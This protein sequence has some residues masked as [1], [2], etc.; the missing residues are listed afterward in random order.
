LPHI[1]YI[2]AKFKEKLVDTT[3]RVAEKNGK[4]DIITIGGASR[5]LHEILDRLAIRLSN[6]V[7]AE[8]L[9]SMDQTLQ[10]EVA[11]RDLQSEFINA[12]E[13][14]HQQIYATLPNFIKLLKLILKDDIPSDSVSSFI[15]SYLLALLPERVEEI[16]VLK[17]SHSLRTIIDHANHSK[18]WNWYTTSYFGRGFIVYPR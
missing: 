15:D 14:F 18:T 11:T 1:I 8:K 17:R 7:K 16:G 2:D 9:L 4:R 12:T 3:L 5:N 13:S 10:Q 6:L